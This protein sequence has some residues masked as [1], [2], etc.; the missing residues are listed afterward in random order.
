[1]RL[2]S[3][4]FATLMP[5]AAFAGSLSAQSSNTD[6]LL[7]GDYLRVSG[8]VLSPIN[9]QGSL[10]EWDR[11]PTVNV[12]WENWQQGSN[13]VGLVG[14]AFSFD[15]SRLPFKEE[16]FLSEFQT[17]QGARA[18]SANASADA[19]MFQL[20][21]AIRV[22][23]PSPFIMP[24]LQLGFGILSFQ[25]G[26]ISYQTATGP[27]TTSQRHRTGG[28]ISLGGGVDKQVYGRVALFGEALYTYAFTSLGGQAVATAG[29]VCST[30][31]ALKNTATGVIRGGL[32]VR[33]S[34]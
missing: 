32:R 20:S 12:A 29:G 6:G 8:G 26:N 18:T 30:C 14:F 3:F 2:R 11:G 19:Q 17:A 7:P 27:G 23:I 10:R 33:V 4:A 22:R 21:T 25:P 9:S 34:R 24:N 15:Y 31:D 13:G 28:A 5:F 1:M 16:A